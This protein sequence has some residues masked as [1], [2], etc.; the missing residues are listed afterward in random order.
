MTH[1]HWILWCYMD[2]DSN[3][4]PINNTVVEVIAGTAEEAKGKALRLLPGKTH[5]RIMNVIEHF[6]ETD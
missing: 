3:G 6:G 4:Q 2:I 5:Y 1:L